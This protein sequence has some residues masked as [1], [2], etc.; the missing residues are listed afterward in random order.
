MGPVGSK[1]SRSVSKSP[2]PFMFVLNMA[3]MTRVGKAVLDVLGDSDDWVR[4]LH[5]KCTIDEEKRYICQ[6]PRTT[7]F[8]SVNSGYGGNVLLGK[9]ALLS[10]LLPTRAKNEGWMAEHMLILGIENPQGETKYIAAAFP[11]AC[12][13]TNLAMLIPP[14]VPTQRRDTRF[15][16]SATTL[17]GCALVRTAVFGP[18]TPRPVSSAWRPAPTQIQLQRA[19][20]P[21]EGHHFHQ[22]C[23]QSRRQHRV[24]GRSRQES[25]QERLNWKGEKWDC[26][27]GSQGSASQQPFHRSR[28]QL[29]LPQQA[30][31]KSAEGVPMSAIVFGGRRAKTAPLG[32]QAAGLEPRRI[33]R[34]HYGLRDHRR[35]KRC[36]R[37]CPP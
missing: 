37:R 19:G 20:F 6:F 22:R 10:E 17:P 36:G 14:E 7:P 4:G 26:T 16:P 25:S 32:Y 34:L 31:S 2:I 27:D 8:W 18:S 12:G 11:S 3:I 35:R 24:V 9:N 30:S 21:P 28:E 29:P 1:F 23:P 15:G 5:C 13:K 33:C